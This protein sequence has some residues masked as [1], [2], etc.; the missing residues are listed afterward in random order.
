MFRPPGI[1]PRRTYFYDAIITMFGLR[2]RT[3]WGT[4]YDLNAKRVKI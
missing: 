4:G 3:Q 2:C 1:A